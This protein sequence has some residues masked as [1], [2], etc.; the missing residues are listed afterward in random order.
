M[1]AIAVMT[2]SV[3]RAV[4]E[5]YAPAL[6]IAVM[7]LPVQNAESARTMTIPV[8]PQRR[9]RLIASVSSTGTCPARRTRASPA[10]E[11]S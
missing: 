5:K 10:T 9:A 6:R 4:T 1:P 8:A 2:A 7:I 11:V 3:F